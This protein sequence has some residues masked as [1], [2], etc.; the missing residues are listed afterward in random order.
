MNHPLPVSNGSIERKFV[1]SQIKKLR[2][3]WQDA[4]GKQA[5]LDHVRGSVGLILADICNGLG[6]TPQERIEVLGQL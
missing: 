2:Q 3:E 4:V 1:V 5:D 6:F